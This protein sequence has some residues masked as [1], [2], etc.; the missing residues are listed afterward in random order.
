M[1]DLPVGR[2][3]PGDERSFLHRKLLRIGERIALGAGGKR[4]VLEIGSQLPGFIGQASR[5][6]ARRPSTARV[7]PF[8]QAERTRA[9]IIKFGEGFLGFGGNGQA[10][11]CTDPDLVRNPQGQCVSPG[12]P[13]GAR[14]LT[15]EPVLG[16][17]GAGIRPGSMIIDRAVCGK[18]MQLGD[19]G[20]CYNKSQISNKQRMWP[21]GR[22]PLLTG[23]D[24]RAI[25]VAS[26]AGK[27]MDAAT[28]RLRKLGMMKKAPATRR[29]TKAEQQH[30]QLALVH[31]TK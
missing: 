4:G 28:A 21:A 24:M 2:A 27:R 16:I 14:T 31:A 9:T 13:F 12:S 20:I 10:G 6:L 25:S 5:A 18:K 30:Q 11:P 7:T 26:R 1:T 19:D 23:G 15:G 8:S 3:R 17:Y 29:P 22:K